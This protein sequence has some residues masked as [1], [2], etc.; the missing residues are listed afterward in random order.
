M[1]RSIMLA[2]LLACGVVPATVSAQQPVGASGPD[3]FSGLY[4]GGEIGYD[5][6]D[7]SVESDALGFDFDNDFDGANF[8]G[9]VGY[10]VV[11]D[12]NV[13]IG[14]EGSAGFST[15]SEFFGEDFQDI[16]A[17][18][19]VGD[20]EG[21][22]NYAVDGRLG[23][24]VSPQFLVFGQIGFG[25][26]RFDDGVDKSFEEGLRYGAG[27]QF[28]LTE[29]LSIRA[30]WVHTDLIESDDDNRFAELGLGTELDR[31]EYSGALIYTF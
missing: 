29:Q 19:D 4:A 10:N 21:N 1:N 31:N 15:A 2:A 27:A 9:I 8:S 24:L 7:F 26:V 13:L 14:V 16:D 22:F 3:Y 28:A 11:F 12:N 17:F 6:F 5:T 18:E 30:R 20:V 25:G 23:Y